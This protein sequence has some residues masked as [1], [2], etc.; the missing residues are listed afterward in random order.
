M[1]TRRVNMDNYGERRRPLLFQKAAAI[2]AAQ[3]TQAE[4]IQNIDVSCTQKNLMH[5][6]KAFPSIEAAFDPAINVAYGAKY[7]AALHRETSSWFTAVKRYHSAHP[8]FHLPYRGRVFRIWR[9][10]KTKHLERHAHRP[11]KEYELTNGSELMSVE[12]DLLGSRLGN[13]GSKH[14]Q[15]KSWHSAYE[16]ARAALEAYEERNGYLLNR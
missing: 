1:A 10:I 3:S 6:K 13:S 9:N 7:L 14:H 8:K 15:R 12:I 2:A 16:R 5:H 11:T 4:G